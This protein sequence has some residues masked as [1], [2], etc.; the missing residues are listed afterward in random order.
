MSSSKLQQ[1]SASGVEVHI[2]KLKA[3]I[4]RKRFSLEKVKWNQEKKKKNIKFW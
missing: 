4:Y 3:V 1:S 2:V